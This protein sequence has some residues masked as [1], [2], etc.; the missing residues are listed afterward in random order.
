MTLNKIDS[1]LADY[2]YSLSE[3]VPVGRLYLSD[4]NKPAI[5][6]D[7]TL[8]NLSLSSFQY[9]DYTS[10][11]NRIMHQFNGLYRFLATNMTLLSTELALFLSN[12]IEELDLK[13]YGADRS[14][15]H[16]D[17]TPPEFNFALSFEQVFGAKHIHA[18]QAE[19]P[20]VDRQGHRRYIDYVLHRNSQP[21]AIELNGEQ[22]HHPLSAIVSEKKYR[23][24]LFKQNSLVNDGYH[25]F[26][27]SNRGMQDEFKFEDQIKEY[28]GNS[29]Y[30]Q[31]APL[32]RSIRKVYFSLYDH[33][34]KA[35]K[36]L[37]EKRA[38]GEQTFLIVL[39]TGT[40]KTEV[41]IEDFRQ[42]FAQGHLKRALA[43]VPSTEL[44]KQLINRVKSQLPEIRVGDDF[45]GLKPD[46]S[47]RNMDFLMREATFMINCDQ[48]AS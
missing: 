27:W 17:P 6:I 34:Q 15:S 3:I 37:Q 43:I 7:S 32:Y 38:Q 9:V 21:I 41:F 26:R 39:P 16:I 5:L 30:F 36:S 23:S 29:Q 25:V 11:Q 14:E 22:Y 46:E 47:P 1:L 28:F 8:Y 4:K 33:Q 44:K 12:G 18:L 13:T 40:G 24:Q 10:Y 45:Y 20:Y 42:E 19:A 35:V 2:N 48:I 31:S